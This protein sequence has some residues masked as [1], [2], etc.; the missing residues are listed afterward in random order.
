LK[1]IP[2]EKFAFIRHIDLETEN[3][4]EFIN[5][6]SMRT[7]QSLNDYSELVEKEE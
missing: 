5:K 2:V 7:K 1:Q 4:D 3:K 6:F